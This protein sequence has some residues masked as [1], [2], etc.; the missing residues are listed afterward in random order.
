M[1]DQVNEFFI[2]RAQLSEN[3]AGTHIKDKDY[4][5]AMK[6]L[7]QAYGFYT[8]AGLV[9]DA[10]RI[11]QKYAEIKKLKDAK[12]GTESTESPEE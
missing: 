8:K 3:I 2:K 7:N 11:K 6:N 10:Q 9:E 1:P 5:N 4:E 12:E